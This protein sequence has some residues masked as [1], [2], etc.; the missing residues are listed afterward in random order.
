MASAKRESQVAATKPKDVDM[1]AFM[2]A[3]MTED[4]LSVVGGL[5]PIC[6]PEEMMG[7][8]VG[9]WI[10]AIIDMPPRK[11]KSEWRALLV[12]LTGAC[13]AKVGEEVQT[14][15]AGEEV[16]IPLNGSLKN[17]PDL[18]N[19]AASSSHVFWGFLQCV[20]QVDLGKPS[21]MWDFEVKLNKKNP[22][23]RTGKY[24]LHQ[25]A[26]QV[27]IMGSAI[28]QLGKDAITNANGQPAG[29]M[30]G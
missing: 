9:G 14:I 18:L 20:G 19:A 15:E 23:A 12:E 26:V 10:V 1:K 29:S 25:S 17:N 6:Q 16:L 11:D 22:I 21:P 30:V 8:P 4:D 27:E 3:G 28:P 24:A 2:P 5:R 7:N 13:R